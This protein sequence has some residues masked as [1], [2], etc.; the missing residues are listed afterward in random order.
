MNGFLVMGIGHKHDV[1]L[2]MF[3][4]RDTAVEFAED[5]SPADVQAAIRK[6][7]HEE[8]GEDQPIGVVLAPVK[9][10]EPQPFE[11]MKNFD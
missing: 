6:A 7:W 4:D 8:A 1:P 5:V 9:D 2:A 3:E 10:S 11:S